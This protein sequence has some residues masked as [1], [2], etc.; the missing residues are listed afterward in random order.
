MRKSLK[1]IKEDGAG[2]GPPT[3]NVSGGHVAGLGVGPQG[4]PGGPTSLFRKKKRKVTEL[5]SRK[6]PKN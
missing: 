2:G 6:S 4:E 3:N 5:L 1:Q